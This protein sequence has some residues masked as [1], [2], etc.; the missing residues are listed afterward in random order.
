MKTVLYDYQEKTAQNIFDRISGG[1]ING[2]Y[3]G[4]ETGCVCGDNSVTVKLNGVGPSHV[5]NMETL[6]KRWQKGERFTIKSM[7]NGRFCFMPIANV[8]YSGEKE[9]LTIHTDKD[10]IQHGKLRHLS[11]TYDHPIFC[12]KGFKEA[13]EFRVGDCILSNGRL[14]CEYCGNT[15][16]MT[17]WRKY[18]K[19]PGL[20]KS[21]SHH[22]TSKEAKDGHY[23][24]ID[25]DGYVWVVDDSLR[26][27]SEYR[28]YL[29]CK[30]QNT[31]FRRGI[32]KHRLVM[33]QHLN[34]ELT[35][36]E[37]VHHIDHNKCNNDISNLQLMTFSE[38]AKLHSHTHSKHLSQYNATI[39]SY[40]TKNRE[41]ILLYTTKSN[42]Y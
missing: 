2:A 25:K 1:E 35:E 12:E 30:E 13:Q 36:N 20:C 22:M 21:C 31:F 15:L 16:K 3:L 14:V 17:P 33:M 38:H 42:Y 27:Y 40:T 28:D 39:E 8:I 37:V 11:C 32:A 26:N 9:C 4:F 10:R 34:R 29:K 41:T 6:Y 5:I 23:E 18:N 7:V 19:Y 24:Y